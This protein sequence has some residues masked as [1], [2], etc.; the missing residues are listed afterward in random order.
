MNAKWKEDYRMFA[1]RHKV[2]I[3]YYHK[4]QYYKD[5]FENCF[6]DIF[7]NKSVGDGEIN[8]D[9]STD[10]IKR[11]IQENYISDSSVIV[12]LIGRKPYCRKHVDWDISAKK[13]KKVGGYSG[14][15]GILLPDFPFTPEGKYHFENIPPRLADNVRS[16]YAKVYSWNW[17]CSNQQRIRQAIDEAFQIKNDSPNK[18]DN[19]RDQFLY[20]R[21]E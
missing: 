18:I 6:N 15:I 11:L 21:C 14:L 8:T 9:V 20:N 13:K 4:D 19:S 7:I 5:I 3:S 2:F 10:Y 16:D 12:V 1:E 17:V